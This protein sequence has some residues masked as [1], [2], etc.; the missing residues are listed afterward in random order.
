MI[1]FVISKGRDPDPFFSNGEPPQDP[2]RILV[3]TVKSTYVWHITIMLPTKLKG[4]TTL[5]NKN[6]N[7]TTK[8]LLRS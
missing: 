3:E 7:Y 2:F 1:F 4:Y 5:C 6:N 8:W